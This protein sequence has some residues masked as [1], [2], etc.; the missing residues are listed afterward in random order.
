MSNRKL[1]IPT[2]KVFRP[3]LDPARY[4]GA[5]GGR[6]SAKS[7]FFGG[8]LIEDHLRHRGLASVCI[9]EVQKTLKQ[10]AKRL[11]V[12]KLEELGLNEADGFKVFTEVIQTPGNGLITFQG[13]QDHT[14]ES[15]KSLEDY[16]RAWVEEGQT[17]SARSLQLLRPTIRAPG[18]ELWFSWNPRRRTDPV[19]QMLRGAELPTGAVVVQSN[20]RDN[21]WFPAELEQ[22]RRDCLRAE[23]EQYDHTWEGG[24]VSIA[25]G[26]YYAKQLAEARLERRIGKVPRDRLATV[27]AVWDIGGTGQKADACA[28]WL[29][30]FVGKEILW[31]DYRETVGAELAEHVEW[32]RANGYGDALC[33]L[34]HDGNTHD[35]VFRVSYAGMLKAAGFETLVLPNQGA[36]AAGQRVQALRR[37]FPQCYFDADKCAPGLEALAWYHEKKDE[38]RNV[39]LGPEHDWASHGADAA[40]LVAVHFET[41]PAKR[42]PVREATGGAEVFSFG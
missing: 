27:R 13:M 35:K 30:Q 1:E 17:I 16:G 29:V 22:E 24:Y 19:D 33:V 11:I 14:A 31:I 4:K 2:A 8:L 39:G 28:I 41:Q 34:P 25:A 32:L 23:P 40:G 37:V 9:R 42:R 7:H 12:R 36:G 20:W 26:A 15:I 18:S 21:P 38:A 6:G 10:S 5:H 3:L